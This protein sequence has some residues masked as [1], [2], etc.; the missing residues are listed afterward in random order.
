MNAQDGSR[1]CTATMI[2][3]VLLAAGTAIGAM[4]PQAAAADLRDMAGQP[5]SGE[6]GL[7]WKYAEVELE[8]GFKKGT[9]NLPF[10]G[11]IQSTHL[12]GMV[13]AARPLPGDK[14]TTMTGP[15]AWKSPA[16]GKSRCGIVVPV[17]YTPAV[18]GLARTILTVRTTAGSFSFQPI[19]LELGPI[20]TP[21]YGF[22]VRATGQPAVEP[23]TPPPP[24]NA[25]LTTS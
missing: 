11:S 13:G 19:D 18:R 5:V 17:L 14:Q 23:T 10:D 21:E 1:E 8:W 16:G 4:P 2:A 9:E 24:T 15:L 25:S 7:V 22:F 3:L 12:L 6:N 20:L